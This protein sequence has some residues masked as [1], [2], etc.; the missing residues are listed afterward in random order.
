MENWTNEEH[1]K[2]HKAKA[3]K[4]LAK[5]KVNEA[6]VRKVPEG[7]TWKWVKE[8]IRMYKRKL[9]PIKNGKQSK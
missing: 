4:A 7:Y 2:Y 1:S 6:S 8:G 3:E 5:A 9:I